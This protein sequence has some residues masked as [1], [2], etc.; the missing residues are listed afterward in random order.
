LALGAFVFFVGRLLVVVAHETAHALTMASFGRSIGEAGVKL[1]LVFPYAYV[2]TSD[3]WFEPRRRRIAVS[4][5]GPICDLTVGGAFALWCLATPAGTMRDVIVQ[6][7]FG[8]Y[9]GA[10]FN[11]NPLLERDGYQILVDVLR[12]PGLRPRALEFLRNRLAGRGVTDSRLLRRYA[13]FSIAWTLVTVAFAI[14]M[15]LRYEQVLAS[16]IPLPVVW[17]FYAAIWT[18]L[19][20]LPLAIV[21]PPLRERFR[22]AS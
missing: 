16:R 17:A 11:L 2:D 12:A 3:A 14:A 22:S 20:A 1:L 13:L 5:A 9:L 18:G 15:S 7:S 21:G 6:L 10:L 4:A 8:A 19:L